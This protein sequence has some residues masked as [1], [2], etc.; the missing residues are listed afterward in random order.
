MGEIAVNA[1]I[2]SV[3][4][5]ADDYA[6]AKSQADSGTL[7]ARLERLPVT[8]PVLWARGCVGMA[9]FFDGYTTIALAYALPI[10]AKEWGLAPA[11]TA[12]IISSGYLGQLFGAIFFG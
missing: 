7:L 9:T 6:M 12:A 1:S 5:L 2:A 4:R 11:T 8:R 10:L 3:G